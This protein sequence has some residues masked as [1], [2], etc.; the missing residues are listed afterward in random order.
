MHISNTIFQL[1]ACSYNCR[2]LLLFPGTQPGWGCW[3][4]ASH[5][6]CSG[7]LAPTRLEP[8]EFRALFLFLLRT[9]YSL[10]PTRAPHHTCP[11]K[12]CMCGFAVLFLF[13]KLIILFNSSPDDAEVKS[14]INLEMF[15]RTQPPPPT[16]PALLLLVTCICLQTQGMWKEM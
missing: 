2:L 5:S 13:T 14:A 9:F 15:G 10:H 16:T 8:Q 11:S 12:G 4:S 6:V 3:A 1:A 7:D